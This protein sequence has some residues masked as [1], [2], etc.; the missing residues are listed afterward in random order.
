[1]C[2]DRN[3]CKTWPCLHLTLIPAAHSPTTRV[4]MK[5]L[6]FANNDVSCCN[7]AQTKQNADIHSKVNGQQADPFS[8]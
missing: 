1:M 5:G 3:S 2:H 6:C 8:V 7:H 4:S